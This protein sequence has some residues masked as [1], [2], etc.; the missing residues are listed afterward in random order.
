MSKDKG[1]AILLDRNGVKY[2]NGDRISVD[3]MSGYIEYC[4]ATFGYVLVED[5]GQVYGLDDLFSDRSPFSLDL[6]EKRKLSLEY[7]KSMS[8][9]GLRVAIAKELGYTDIAVRDVPVP[10]LMDL[11]EPELSG[12]FYG[13]LMVIPRYSTRL[14]AAM[15]LFRPLP[16]PRYIEEKANLDVICSFGRPLQI[17]EVFG[18]SCDNSFARAISCAYLLSLQG[19]K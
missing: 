15:G 10:W 13:E 8:D 12:Y 4:Q 6:A 19:K 16:F 7:I 9:Y 3:G 5:N 1:P 17:V 18:D 14:D 11:V 2:Y